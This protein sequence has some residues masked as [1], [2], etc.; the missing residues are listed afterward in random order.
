[1]PYGRHLA[2]AKYTKNSSSVATVYEQLDKRGLIQVK[3]TD[4]A[5]FLQGLITNDMRYLE[6]YNGL[7]LPCMYAV[8]LSVQGDVLYDIIVYSIKNEVDEPNT[9]FFLECDL[10]GVEEL[11]KLFKIY[12]IRKKV[13]LKDMTKEITPW[14]VY[15]SDGK[16]EN[17]K[18]ADIPQ[19]T[20]TG[21]MSR[22]MFF[23]KDPRL[24][25]L[26]W[27]LLLPK[28]LDPRHVIE[29]QPV[30]ELGGLANY[31][32]LRLQLGVA[33]GVD[34]L[35]PGKCFPLE[36]NVDLL[37]GVNFHKGCYLG[38]ELTART[39]HTGVI[40]KRLM[41]L[42]FKND[43]ENEIPFDT[44]IVNEKGRN[45]GRLVRKLGSHGLG[46]MRIQEVEGSQEL[47][48]K[49]HG[50]LVIAAKPFWWPT[51]TAAA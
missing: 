11:T 5:N 48:V 12:R 50:L 45:V 43:V 25:A 4:A 37:H 29:A 51:E 40:R 34:D 28:N 31:Q 27:R 47:K 44:A 6:N 42:T 36:C 33:E 3:G 16:L 49:G 41:P 23:G 10:N 19:P 32:H 38:Q 14:V 20:I 35:P 9:N 46:M 26:G 2:L 39:H 15:G 1:M 13:E 7:K 30:G 22:I 24:N 21:N 18:L 8:I 17:L